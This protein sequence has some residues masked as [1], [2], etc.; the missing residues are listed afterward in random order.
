MATGL[1][2]RKLFLIVIQ[3]L[4]KQLGAAMREEYVK[5]SSHCYMHIEFDLPRDAPGSSA[6]S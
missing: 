5:Q 4:P 6:L 1:A 3:A 2:V